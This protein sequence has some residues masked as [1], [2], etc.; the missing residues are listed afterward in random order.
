M[1]KCALPKIFQAS[2]IIDTDYKNFNMFTEEKKLLKF[3]RERKTRKF[4][5]HYFYITFALSVLR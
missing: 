3:L 1:E 2:L 5:F 4:D